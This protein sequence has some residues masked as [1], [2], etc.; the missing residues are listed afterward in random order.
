MFAVASA[1]VLTLSTTAFSQQ[2]GQIPAT[3]PYC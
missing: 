2:W 3:A 1:A